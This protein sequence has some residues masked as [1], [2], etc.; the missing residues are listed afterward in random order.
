MILSATEFQKSI[1]SS[2][3]RM[4]CDEISKKESEVFEAAFRAASTR[5]CQESASGTLFQSFGVQPFVVRRLMMKISLRRSSSGISSNSGTDRRSQLRI[6]SGWIERFLPSK[7]A[8]AG[9]N[10]F[11]RPPR[12]TLT[13]CRHSPFFFA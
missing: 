9:P 13:L 1:P 3:S 2:V 11:S 6:D 12:Q 4:R 10:P 8:A 5:R 7:L